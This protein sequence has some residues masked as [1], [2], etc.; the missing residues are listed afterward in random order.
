MHE[1]YTGFAPFGPATLGCRRRMKIYRPTLV[2][3]KIGVSPCFAYIA[4][5]AIFREFLRKTPR[6]SRYPTLR[7]NGSFA[8]KN[9][10]GKFL[11]LVELA[12][13]FT[14]RD[15]DFVVNE[16][17]TK[18]DKRMNLSGK[19]FIYSRNAGMRMRWKVRCTCK[20]TCNND[21]QIRFSVLKEI[22]IRER[23]RKKKCLKEKVLFDR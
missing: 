3:F 20:V 12:G 16:E 2:S 7:S 17:R 6:D 22:R 14:F 8:G 18:A 15:L 19:L 9:G 11:F 1:S 4:F 5:F 10:E 13:I 23:M 21:V